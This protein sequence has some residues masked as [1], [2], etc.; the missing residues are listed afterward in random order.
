MTVPD[1]EQGTIEQYLH[2]N[3]VYQRAQATDMPVKFTDSLQS[4]GNCWPT[5]SRPSL[6]G[7]LR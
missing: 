1:R 7:G 4:V 5:I 6:T 3:A 2:R